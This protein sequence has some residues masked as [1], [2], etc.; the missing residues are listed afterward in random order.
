MI[1]C[2]RDTG[3]MNL[4]KTRVTKPCTFFMSFPCS[5]HITAHCICTQVKN[6]SISTSTKQHGM[7]K[8]SFQ[9]TRDQIAADDPPCFSIDHDH[10]QHFMT[11]VHFYISESNLSFQCLVGADQ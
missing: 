7:S 5:G 6:I 3:W 4:R 10:I 9:V 11:A 1:A 2:D 8:K